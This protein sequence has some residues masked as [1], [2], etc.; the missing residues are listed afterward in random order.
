VLP[1]PDGVANDF[2]QVGRYLMMRCAPQT[3]GQ[4]DAEVRMYKAA[5]PEV[6]TEQFYETDPARGYQRGFSIQTVSP[7]PITWAEHIT[8]QGH[9]GGALRR[10]AADAGLS[11][12]A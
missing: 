8:A 2:D 7:L 4:F 10:A 1:V 3:A 9:W 11:S 12:G 5:P 6:S